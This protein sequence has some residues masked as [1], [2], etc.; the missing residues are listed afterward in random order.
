MTDVLRRPKIAIWMKKKLHTHI[1]LTDIGIP[2]LCF[3][4]EK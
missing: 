3:Y 1:I 2:L 4:R